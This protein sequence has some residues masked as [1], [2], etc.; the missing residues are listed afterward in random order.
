MSLKKMFTKLASMFS[1]RRDIL[2]PD[3]WMYEHKATLPKLRSEIKKQIYEKL[4][5]VVPNRSHWKSIVIIGSITGYRYTETSDIDVNVMVEPYD[6]AYHEKRRTVNGF[7]AFGTRH[8]V[9]FMIQE[10]HGK[11]NSNFWQ[12]SYFGVYD[13]INDSWL[14][15]PPPK[16][17]YREATE[18]FTLEIQMAQHTAR[19]FE[20]L[21]NSYKADWDQLLVLKSRPIEDFTHP[22]DKAVL[23]EKKQAELN[24][25]IT[26]LINF[27]QDVEARRKEA[28]MY[29][30][31]T[32]R[33]TFPNL[34]YKLL[35][36]G[37]YG[38]F[39][40]KLQA[41]KQPA[42]VKV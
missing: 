5:K 12:D 15:T 14:A 37:K 23:I 36:Y 22:S 39:F 11:S 7:Y 19:H 40:L 18:E 2:S 29:G 20:Y 42:K 41:I 21:V 25:D 1:K 17:T 27:A 33:K 9:N 4:I 28:Y 31:G 10:W 16:E 24:D 35:E 38:E 8:P 13:V 26:E 32:P 34:L 30:W 3:I 6:P